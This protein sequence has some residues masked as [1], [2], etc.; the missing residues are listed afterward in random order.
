MR[1]SPKK[2]VK[3]SSRKFKISDYLSKKIDIF[4]A[5]LFYLLFFA[6]V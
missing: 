5:E 3:D 4:L 2:K 6:E 1:R